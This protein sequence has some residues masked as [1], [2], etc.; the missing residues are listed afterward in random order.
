MRLL[1]PEDFEPWVGRKVRVNTPPKPVEVTL[2]RIERRT[3][4]LRDLAARTIEDAPL[5]SGGVRLR[6]H[7]RPARG[8]S[9][10]RSRGREN[11]FREGKMPSTQM[12]ALTTVYGCMLL[13]GTL[14]PAM[15]VDPLRLTPPSGTVVPVAPAGT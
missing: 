1:A 6:A 11:Q 10:R 9:G 7:G 15:L 14:L 13:M 2:E 8:R 12:I 4:Q 5:L 3:V